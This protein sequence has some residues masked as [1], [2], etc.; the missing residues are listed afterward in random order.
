M[1]YRVAYLERE[2]EE[3]RETRRRAD[4]ILAQLSRANAEQART[5]RALEGPAAEPPASEPPGASERGAAATHTG[6]GHGG[7]GEAQEAQA[8]RLAWREKWE[9]RF[10][11]V[12]IAIVIVSAFLLL[13]VAVL[14]P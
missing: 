7:L 11:G 4:A 9:M 3:E 1:R 12:L 5:I 14:P 6:A 13:A 8:P 10:V 2:V